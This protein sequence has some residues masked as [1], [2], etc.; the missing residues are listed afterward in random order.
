MLDRLSIRSLLALVVVL[1]MSNWLLAAS[2]VIGVAMAKGGFR[3]N[4]AAVTGNA[5]L[6]DGSVVE[7]AKAS[8][9]IRLQSGATLNLAA[10]SRGRVFEH[11]A[12]LERGAGEVSGGYV[13]EAL[14]LRVESDA[15]AATARLAVSQGKLEVAALTGSFRVLNN[16]G[17]LVGNVGAGRALAFEPQ[18]AGAA[19]PSTLTGCLSKSDGKYYL[20]DD[21]SGVKVQLTGSKLENEAGNRVEVVGTSI[22]SDQVQVNTLKRLSRGCS[23][24]GA[25]AAAGGGKAAATGA[26]TAG[27]AASMAAGTKAVIAGVVVA[28]AA[29]TG[30]GVYQA[31]RDETPTSSR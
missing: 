8:S 11:R 7:T 19:A 14:G 9:N 30:A 25:A 23:A 1:A 4:D 27:K 29:G 26:A 17:F 6:F 20:T 12:V 5:T 2:P 10:S 18:A 22:G 15:P 28:A 13:M 3:V 16:A 21:A 24:A 31:T